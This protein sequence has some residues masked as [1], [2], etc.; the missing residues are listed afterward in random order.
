M[1]TIQVFDLQAVQKIRKGAVLVAL[2]ALVAAG[3]ATRRAA[4]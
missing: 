2:L 4:D 3:L 1:T